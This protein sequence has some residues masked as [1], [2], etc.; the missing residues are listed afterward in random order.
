MNQDQR[1]EHDSNGTGQSR[2]PTSAEEAYDAFIAESELRARKYCVRHGRED[3][4]DIFQE[5]CLALWKERQRILSLPGE[6]QK[7]WFWGVLKKKIIDR[8]R[9]N[10][11]ESNIAPNPPDAELL[12]DPGEGP[13][14]RVES[15]DQQEQL[16][17]CLEELPA[18]DHC[19][20]L[21]FHFEEKP[22]REIAEILE[23][24]EE[25]VRRRRHKAMKKL[26]MCIERKRGCRGE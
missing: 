8:I 20:V 17:Q 14:E 16:R 6:E 2:S 25:S 19:C 15:K 13:P 11:R 18:V 24:Q 26:R 1:P 4:E 3:P 12:P 9:K 7:K 23:I 22:D 5:A 21:L 10:V